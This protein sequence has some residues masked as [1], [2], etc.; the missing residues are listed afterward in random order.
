MQEDPFGGNGIQHVPQGPRLDVPRMRM[1]RDRYCVRIG[2]GAS[3]G[4]TRRSGWLY[5]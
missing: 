1:W 2:A 4:R 3:L 5:T